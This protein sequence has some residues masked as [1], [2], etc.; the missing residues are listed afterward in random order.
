M[1]RS[2]SLL[3]IFISFILVTV[4]IGWIA[5]WSIEE[6]QEIVKDILLKSVM[7][8]TAIW[9]ILATS[10]TSILHRGNAPI[11]QTI[12][13]LFLSIGGLGLVEILSGGLPR[14]NLA[15]ITIQWAGFAMGAAIVLFTVLAIATGREEE[16]DPLLAMDK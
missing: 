6:T 11:L 3:S 10:S 8:M 12:T 16:E 5:K 4:I 2:N 15:T 13:L 1:N 7:S 14:G 9:L